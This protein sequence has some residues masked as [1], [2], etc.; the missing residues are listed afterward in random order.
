MAMS[1]AEMVLRVTDE[2]LQRLVST[3]TQ[4]WLESMGDDFERAWRECP[5]TSLFL[6]LLVAAGVKSREIRRCRSEAS[7]AILNEGKSL[8]TVEAH[9][10]I[11][12][13]LRAEFPHTVVRH[14]GREDESLH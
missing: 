8:D 1:V 2:G 4:H 5:N 9:D 12:N 6:V 14:G 11:L 10:R 13:A 7:M 3:E